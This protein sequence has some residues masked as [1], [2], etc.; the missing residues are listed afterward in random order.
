MRAKS[1]RAEQLIWSPAK[2]GI[3]KADDNK[4]FEIVLYSSSSGYQA[5]DFSYALSALRVTNSE[6][7]HSCFAIFI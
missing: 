3:L 5:G 4:N 2:P 7:P 6:S 1:A